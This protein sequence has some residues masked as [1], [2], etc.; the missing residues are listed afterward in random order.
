MRIE[1]TRFRVRE[2]A[3][4]LVDEWLQFLNDNAA[5]VRETLEPEQM[6][7]E[8][9]FSEFVGGVGYLYWYSIQGAAGL[10]LEQSDHWLD[11]KHQNYWRARID[12]DFPPEDLSPRVTMIP[13]RVE[14]AMR[15][16]ASAAEEGV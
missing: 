16:L 9:I 8:T 14:A 10:G 11:E 6:Y 4:D 2:G 1:L 5:A 3:D 15:P 7:V 13:E 12:D